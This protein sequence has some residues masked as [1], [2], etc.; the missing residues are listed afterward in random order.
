[1]AESMLHRIRPSHLVLGAAGVAMFLWAWCDYLIFSPMRRGFEE[2]GLNLSSFLKLDTGAFQDGFFR[3]IVSVLHPTH[4]F[5]ASG[6]SAWFLLVV[7]VSTLFFGMRV[8]RQGDQYTA[9]SWPVLAVPPFVLGLF[10]VPLR[11]KYLFRTMADKGLSDPRHVGEIVAESL[12][13]LYI[14]F[15]GSLILAAMFFI[16]RRRLL[17]AQTGVA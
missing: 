9:P 16:V 17:R 4:A 5:R 12:S 10:L 6:Q 8:L 3:N 15:I 13:P 2:T 14:A 7:I 11:L 1:M